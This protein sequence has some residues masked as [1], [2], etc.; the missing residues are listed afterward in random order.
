LGTLNQ[1]ARR[2][3]RLPLHIPIIVTALASA[4]NSPRECRTVFVNA[5]GCAIIVTEQIISETRVMLKLVSNGSNK[6][7]RVV[8]AIA[9]PENSS[10]L[11]GVE[12]DSPGNFWEVDNPPADWGDVSNVR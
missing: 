10:W 5:H 7:G 9:L 4:P 12:F 11:L 3:T 8:L 6:E 2:S 1:D